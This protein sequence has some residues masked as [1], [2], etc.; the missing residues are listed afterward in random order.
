MTSINEANINKNEIVDRAMDAFT[1]AF[2]SY[3]FLTKE[4]FDERV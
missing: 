1:D 3:G 2:A 4:S